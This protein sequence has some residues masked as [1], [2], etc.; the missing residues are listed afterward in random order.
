MKKVV[1]HIISDSIGETADVVVK[2]TASQFG[3]NISRIVRHPYVTEKTVI[4]DVISTIKQNEEET[5][6]IA[7]TVVIEELKEYLVK[8]TEEEGIPT[9]DILG[10][11]ITALSKMAKEAPLM[12]PGLIRKLDKNYFKKIEAVE[13]AVKYDDGKDPRGLMQADIVLVGISRTSK[14]PLSMY[15]AHKGYKVANVPLVPE[16]APPEELFQ[17]NQ[18]KIVGLTVNIEQLMRIRRERLKA[19]GLKDNASYA[20]PERITKELEYAEKIMKRLGCIVIN[21]SNKAVEET[22]NIILQ[23]IKLNNH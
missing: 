18:N 22:S 6:M 20:A 10:P 2:A 9:V 5:G 23:T 12:E 11:M 1:I 15:L 3:D 19:L 17:I 4:D 21:I 14:T 13:F 7:F 16:V 8:R